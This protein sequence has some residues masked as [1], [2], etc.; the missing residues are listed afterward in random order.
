[1]KTILS[2]LLLLSSFSLFSFDN[3]PQAIALRPGSNELFIGGEFNTIIVL[4]ATS[5]SNIRQIEVPEKAMEIS[6]NADGSILLVSDYNQVLFYNPETGEKLQTVA[7]EG[8]HLFPNSPYFINYQWYRNNTLIVYSVEDASPMY[9][10]ENKN[11]IEYA[12]FNA[13]FSEL[14]IVGRAMDISGEGKLLQKKVEKREGFDPFNNELVKQQNDGKGS[15]FT[16]ISISGNKTLLDVTIPY[17]ASTSF[18][19]SLTKYKDDYYAIGFDMFIKITKEGLAWPIELANSSFAYAAGASPDQKIIYF[20]AMGKI[21][22]YDCSTGTH[23]EMDL[24]ESDPSYAAAYACTSEKV[25]A[26]NN[27]MEVHTTNPKGVKQKTVKVRMTSENGFAV[28]YYNGFTKK[29]ARDKEALIINNVLAEMGLPAIDLESSTGDSDFLLGVFQSQEEAEA[30]QRRI[31]D[32]GLQYI[33]QVKAY[34]P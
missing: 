30:F 21:N 32:D 26:L 3:D 18:A 24:D 2:I 22:T 8:A 11:P 1:M 29:E 4:D 16:V 31:D 10:F 27:N 15:S 33:T 20:G 12:S 17:T 6:F 14:M 7:I 23:F 19:F 25:Y 13:D 5:G 34:Q 28:Y 9:S